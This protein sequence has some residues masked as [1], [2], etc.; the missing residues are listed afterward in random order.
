MTKKTP[1]QKAADKATAQTA[2]R[3]AQAARQED[4]NQPAPE[5]EGN[6]DKTDTTS[7]EGQTAVE[8]EDTVNRMGEGKAIPT[9]DELQSQNWT[10]EEFD[11]LTAEE[12]AQWIKDVRAEDPNQEKLDLQDGEGVVNRQGSE[13][14]DATVLATDSDGHVTAAQDQKT[15]E[16]TGNGLSDEAIE[17]HKKAEEAYLAGRDK[18]LPSITNMDRGVW[19]KFF[20]DILDRMDALEKK[21][22]VLDTEGEQAKSDLSTLKRKVLD[23]DTLHGST[24]SLGKIPMGD[25]NDK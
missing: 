5:T 21:I 24:E 1:E 4:L 12:Q 9:D 15:G 25:Q 20:T 2:T 17:E 3:T 7:A 22:N 11:G 18:R 13:K 16:V 19:D 8:G 6:A 23:K 10:R 14:G